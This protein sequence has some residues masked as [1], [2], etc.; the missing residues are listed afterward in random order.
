MAKAGHKA[1]ESMGEEGILPESGGLCE[2]CHGH[3]RLK[4]MHMIANILKLLLIACTLGYTNAWAFDSIAGQHDTAGQW[5]ASASGLAASA[6]I[7]GQ[8]DGNDELASHGCD[9]CC[10]ATSHLLALSSNAP[11]QHVSMS[12]RVIVTGDASAPSHIALPDSPPPRR[13]NRL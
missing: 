10:H 12:N 9:H 6:D 11:C 13:L 8:P 1:E 5:Q 7:D 2:S 3:A 4:T